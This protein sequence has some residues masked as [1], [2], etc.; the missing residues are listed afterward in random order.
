[1]A[2]RHETPNQALMNELLEVRSKAEWVDEALRKTNQ[3][4]AGFETEAVKEI[5]ATLHILPDGT[6]A[7]AHS[8]L[9]GAGEELQN[10]ATTYFATQAEIASSSDD[11]DAD[12]VKLSRDGELG[13]PLGKLQTAVSNALREC[14]QQARTQPQ[15]DSAPDDEARTDTPTHPT[16]SA[17][18]PENLTAI[19]T[20]SQSA[21]EDIDRIFNPDAPSREHLKRILQDVESTSRMTRALQGMKS[22]SVWVWSGL[23]KTWRGLPGALRKVAKGVKVANDV[24]RQ[25]TQYWNDLQ[26]DIT[27][28]IHDQVNNITKVLDR[29]AQI[30]Q[31]AQTPPIPAP[32]PRD[33][34]EREAW[35]LETAVAI[36]LGEPVNPA[37]AP[38]IRNLKIAGDNDN[39][40]DTLEDRGADM[41]ALYKVPE[42]DEFSQYLKL[43]TLPNL[44][45]FTQ[46]HYFDL[47]YTQVTDLT[48][49]GTLSSLQTLWLNNTQI[50]DLAPLA[51]LSS[52]QRLSLNNTHVTDLAP[53]APLSGLQEL[54]L[55][56]TQIKDLTP[57]GSFSNL[58]ALDLDNTQVSD[59]TPLST[60]SSLDML[61]LARTQ[62]TDWSPVDHIDFVLGRPDDWKRKTG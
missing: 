11:I 7:T 52:L 6:A 28:F 9:R 35:S 53:L 27:S 31:D 19:E 24:L 56:D 8:H 17:L 25:F 40:Y 13:E 47:D 26:S 43:S 62:V 42:E 60:L 39:L 3:F 15:E 4:P 36:V 33:E 49:L 34:D 55:D 46:L 29:T 20:R 48:P 22:A 44:T 14:R 54:Y 59:L 58:Q 51:T 38:H 2:L 41:A 12:T 61:W 45:D 18:S 50:T 57:L 23:G 21:R 5:L 30:L 32:P 16:D 37:H 10:L 1:M